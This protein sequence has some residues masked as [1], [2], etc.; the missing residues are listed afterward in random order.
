[1][2]RLTHSQFFLFLATLFLSSSISPAQYRGE[3]PYTGNVVMANG[4]PVPNGVEIQLIC[5]A[6]V[7][8]VASP[9]ADGSFSIT[10]LPR[11]LSLA[12]GGRSPSR[13]QQGLGT[14]CD[15]RANL[16]GHRS[17]TIPLFVRISSDNHDLGT[18]ILR[19]AEGIDTGPVTATTA[20]APEEAQQEYK[21]A[22]ESMSNEDWAAAR[23]HLEQA[24]V[25]YNR[26]AEAWYQLGRVYEHESDLPAADAAYHRALAADPQFLRPLLRLCALAL[27]RDDFAALLD[28]SN[29]LLRRNPYRYPTAYYFKGVA[30]FQLRQF[31][32]AEQAAQQAIQLDPG[33]TNPRSHYLLGFI[34]A[35]TGRLEEARAQFQTYLRLSPDANDADVARQ[36]LAQIEQDIKAREG[37]QEQNQ[38]FSQTAQLRN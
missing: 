11:H 1:M 16:G 3:Q 18:L 24:V 32:Q 34:L 29:T 37:T 13:D 26:H 25:L 6:D 7:S 31:E 2:T 33:N 15:L 9:K 27:D 36:T 21:K 28:D 10:S 14:N 19:P 38:F 22:L 12:S 35:N 5:D 17:T 30:H 20:L 8:T 4:D 23:E